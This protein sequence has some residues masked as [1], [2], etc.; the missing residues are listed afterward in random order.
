ML[1]QT[2]LAQDNQLGFNWRGPGYDNNNSHFNPQTSLNRNNVAE[3]N[4]EW[5]TSLTKIPNIYGNETVRST[6][7]LLMVNGFVYLIDRAQILLALN[8]ED[9]RLMWSSI[10]ALPD[11]ERYGIEEVNINSHLLNFFDQK[12][13]L[14]DLDCS[15]K[16]FSGYNGA[17]EV[18]ISSEALCGLIP[19][20]SKP[21]DTTYRAI[22]APILYEEENI[23]IATP[24]GFETQ[25]FP[26]NFIVGI[27]LETQE[28]V[29]KTSLVESET[30]NLN[31]AIGPGVIDQEAGI[32]YVGTGSPVPE[33][34]ATSR[35]GTNL[36]SNSIIALDASNGGIIWHYQTIQHDLNGYGCT[37]NIILSEVGGRKAVFSAA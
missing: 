20:E 35:S 8:S 28:T 22:S 4:Q 13:W 10:L 21:R 1:V 25:D 24:S 19:P 6:S 14:I 7:N 31:L 34:N 26:L 9:S 15:I 16:G 12:V 3:V 11:V 17:V 5:M 37:S 33:W 32:V 27:S 18:E 36:Y 30:D 23:I 2:G 29:W